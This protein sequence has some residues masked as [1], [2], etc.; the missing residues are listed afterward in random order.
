MEPTIRYRPKAV[1]LVSI[2][3]HSG[4]QGLYEEA[5]AQRVH[6]FTH[7]HKGIIGQS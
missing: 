7:C 5:E 2:N 4:S 3:P 6:Q 1:L